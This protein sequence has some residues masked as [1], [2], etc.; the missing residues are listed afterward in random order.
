MYTG[1]ENGD[2]YIVDP[3][4]DIKEDMMLSDLIKTSTPN[5]SDSSVPVKSREEKDMG[6][7][8]M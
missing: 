4:L 6:G 7:M 3:T 1:L 8:E 5:Q 2:R